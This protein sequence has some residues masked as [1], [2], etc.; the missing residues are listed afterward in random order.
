MLDGITKIPDAADKID[1]VST[2]GLLG[3]N[4]SLAY[5]VHEIERHFH[6]KERWLGKKG[7]QTATDWADNVLT[8]FVAISGS[9]TYGADTDDEAL[10]LGIDNTPV[11]SGNVKFDVHRL[12]IV[13]VDHDTPYKIRIIYGS[14]T[15]AEA[16]TAKQ[17]SEVMMQFDSTN[18]QLSAGIPV[19]VMMRRV[20]SGVDKIWAQAWNATDDSEID[21]LIGLHEYAG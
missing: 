19:E 3:K 1:L 16:I 21:F 18:P 20:T 7:T 12:L 9:D 10:V 14:G 5:R 4:N 2:N 11:D 6:N 17:Y 15:M 8:P 13:D